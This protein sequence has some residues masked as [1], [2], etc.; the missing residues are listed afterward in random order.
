MAFKTL[1]TFYEKSLTRLYI[2]VTSFRDLQSD[3]QTR[4]KTAQGTRG[5]S[6]KLKTIAL[7]VQTNGWPQCL[8]G[9]CRLLN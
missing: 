6:S 8:W 1:L 4:T 5:V 9:H 3:P 2:G 7:C